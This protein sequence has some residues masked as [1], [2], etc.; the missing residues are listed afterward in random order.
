M[1]RRLT[2]PELLLAALGASAQDAVPNDGD[3]ICSDGANRGSTPPPVILLELTGE[4]TRPD[5]RN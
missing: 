2:L 1:I 3:L 4:P 5:A